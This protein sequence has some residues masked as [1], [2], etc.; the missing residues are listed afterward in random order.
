MTAKVIEPPD[1]IN[2]QNMSRHICVKAVF[3]IC[4]SN[5]FLIFV[6]IVGCGKWAILLVLFHFLQLWQC[7]ISSEGNVSA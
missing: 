5:P 3:P 7:P 1:I 6:A 2:K 4:E